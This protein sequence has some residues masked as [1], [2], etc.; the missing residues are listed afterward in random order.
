M[1]F[2]LI[3]RTACSVCCIADRSCSARSGQDLLTGGQAIQKRLESLI[4]ARF[5][6]EAAVSVGNGGLDNPELP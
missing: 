6:C 3:S 1:N 4:S 2:S 5:S